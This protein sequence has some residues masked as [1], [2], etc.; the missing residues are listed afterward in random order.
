MKKNDLN[1]LSDLKKTW[2]FEEEQS[3]DGKDAEFKQIKFS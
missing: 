2:I 3:L 1:L